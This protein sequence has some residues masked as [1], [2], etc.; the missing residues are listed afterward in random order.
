M[1]DSTQYVM[2]RFRSR[3]PTKKQLF[4]YVMHPLFHEFLNI[5]L[6]FRNMLYHASIA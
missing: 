3:E 5:D 2:K 4:W 1:F 6:S